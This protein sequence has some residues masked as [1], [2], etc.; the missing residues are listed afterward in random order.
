LN[1]TMNIQ[2]AIFVVRLNGASEL[3]TRVLDAFVP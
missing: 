1:R 3:P 2:A